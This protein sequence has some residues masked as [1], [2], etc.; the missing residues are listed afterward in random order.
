MKILGLDHI[1]IAVWDLESS[2]ARWTALFGARGGPVEEI[3]ARGVRLVKLN[4]PEGPAV[5][6]V[7]PLGKTSPLVKFLEKRGEGIHHICFE[8]EDI[9]PIIEQLVKAGLQFIS[10]RPQ[11]GA[12]GSLIAFIHPQSLNGVLVELK[13]T[14]P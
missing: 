11:Q 5:E 1:G 10:D 2:Q 8:V 9:K 6:L 3:A 7:S 12:A 13:E 4:F 14:G